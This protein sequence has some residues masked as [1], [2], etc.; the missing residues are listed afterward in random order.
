M[1]ASYQRSQMQLQLSFIPTT[2]E[3]IDYF[4][5]SNFKFTP[6]QLIQIKKLNRLPHPINDIILT[7]QQ[8]ID[9]NAYHKEQLLYNLSPQSKANMQI[10]YKK[11]AMKLSEL[12]SNPNVTTMDPYFLKS[13]INS[14]EKI[15]SEKMP[16]F[17]KH[18][19]Y[20]T[21]ASTATEIENHQEVNKHLADINKKLTELLN[22]EL[23]NKE[24]LNKEQNK[25]Q[26][27]PAP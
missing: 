21:Y 22:K 12:F 8:I 3:E 7:E 27:I 17:F 1:S 23:L 11:I 19:L 9:L 6:D 18:L 15:P 25:E 16:E 20:Y 13:F 26:K 24:L 2:S 10:Y 14:N 5:P 4:Y